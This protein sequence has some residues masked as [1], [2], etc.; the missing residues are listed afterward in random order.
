M[1]EVK[2]KEKEKKLTPAMKQYL[3]I[4]SEYPDCI[5]LFRMGDFYELF[6][7]DAIVASKVLDI[8][9]TSSPGVMTPTTPLFTIPFAFDGSSSCS[10]IATLKPSFIRRIT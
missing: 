4:K 7:E 2:E 8:V 6:Y 1:G 9:L 10:H 3:E 5:L